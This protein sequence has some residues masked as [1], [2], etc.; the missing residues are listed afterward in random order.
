MTLQWIHPLSLFPMCSHENPHISEDRIGAGP[1]KS[2]T[3]LSLWPASFLHKL[4]R[5]SICM[6]KFLEGWP[7]SERTGG[8]YTATEEMLW[9]REMVRILSFFGDNHFEKTVPVPAR[10]LHSCASFK[11]PLNSNI[12]SSAQLLLVPLGPE[13]LA[14]S[15]VLPNTSIY[16]SSKILSATYVWGSQQTRH[17]VSAFQSSEAN[18]VP[19]KY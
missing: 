3:C 12:W 7:P 8:F 4:S 15:L 10:Q 14:T 19:F 18:E 5:I 16:S 2:L 11:T 1:N 9:V 17:A 6:R 13:T